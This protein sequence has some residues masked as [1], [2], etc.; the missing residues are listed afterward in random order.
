M[1]ALLSTHGTTRL[2]DGSL[3]ILEQGIFQVA[4]QALRHVPANASSKKRDGALWITLMKHV[5]LREA[6][7]NCD[8]YT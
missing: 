3:H 5:H 4:A 2:C 8:R 1:A 7:D 6:R